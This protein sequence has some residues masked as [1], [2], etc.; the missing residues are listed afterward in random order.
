M[1]AAAEKQE[2]FVR[3]G[4]GHGLG[5]ETVTG[6][7]WAVSINNWV[8]LVYGGELSFQIQVAFFHYGV[9][10]CGAKISETNTSFVIF[11]CPLACHK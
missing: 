2:G 6:G 3:G 11:W 7:L 1:E 9:N 4:G 10:R 8:G 5:I